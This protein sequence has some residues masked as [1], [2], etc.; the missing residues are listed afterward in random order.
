MV[1]ELLSP[2][3]DK[4]IYIGVV[5]LGYNT[6]VTSEHREREKRE[7]MIQGHQIQLVALP[8]QVEEV[9]TRGREEE[10]TER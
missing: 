6:H 1:S 2:L 3:S 7:C 10:E 4:T 8:T 5:C 9:E